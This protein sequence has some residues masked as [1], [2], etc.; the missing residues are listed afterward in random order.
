MPLLS[1]RMTQ[2]RSQHRSQTAC[3]CRSAGKKSG[4][5]GFCDTFCA[6]PQHC[7]PAAAD[8]VNAGSGSGSRR[9]SCVRISRK[10]FYFALWCAHRKASGEDHDDSHKPIFCPA[11]PDGRPVGRPAAAG[12]D[13]HAGAEPVHHD[14]SALSAH[15]HHLFRSSCAGGA[16]APCA[17]APDAALP[18]WASPVWRSTIS[19]SSPVCSSPRSAMPLSSPRPLRP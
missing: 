10:I 7:L 9:G 14:R 15:E 8:H 18:S 4:G 17:A 1:L 6:E 3:P 19:P 5:T 12:Q 13:H 2:N 11:G 16:A